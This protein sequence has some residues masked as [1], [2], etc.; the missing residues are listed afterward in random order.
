M[1][2]LLI[3]P[4]VLVGVVALLALLGSLVPRQHVASRSA[5]FQQRPEVLWQTLTDFA[6]LPTW[7]PE[8]RKV[9]RLPD[10]EGHP[11]W[12]H[13]GPRWQAPMEVVEFDPPRRFKTTISDPRL[14]FGGSWTYQVSPSGG[15][16]VVTITEDGEIRNPV[17]RFLARFVI[18]Y[19]GT[20]DAYLRALGRKHGEAVAPG[21]VVPG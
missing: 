2:W 16:S 14:P 21:P 17:F 11:V 9:E 10:R 4:A 19:T 13:S 5:R 6:K 18:G 3:V 15:G 8:V 12:L 20:M 7:A 1:K